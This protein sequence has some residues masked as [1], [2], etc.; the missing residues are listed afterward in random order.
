MIPAPI[1]TAS[2]AEELR[3]LFDASFAEAPPT[4]AAY[5]NVLNISCGPMACAIRVSDI[6]GIFADVKITRVPSALPELL[7]IAALRGSLVPVYDLR[8]L[9]G[10]SADTRPRW[11]A[12]M[13]ATRLGL[14]FDA[15]EGQKRVPCDAIVS[16]HRDDMLPHVRE[17]AQI[18]GAAR[19]IVPIR[20]LMEDILSRLRAG[21]RDKE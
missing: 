5:E 17:I 16:Q 12:V 21:T 4:T 14:A 11:V 18:D 3:R 1:S 6:S 15:V 20:S 13:A 9:L 7:G 8:T 19:P 10:H 2:R